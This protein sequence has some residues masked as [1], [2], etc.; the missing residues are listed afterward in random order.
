MLIKKPALLTEQDVTDYRLYQQRRQFLK[1]LGGLS[2]WGTG[3]GT[4]L[5]ASKDE[6]T[7]YKDITTYNNFIE[8]GVGKDAPA[9]LGHLIKTS[10]WEVT[11]DGECAK[12]GK[13]DLA[14][15]LKLYPPE[16]RIYS[17]RCV[18]GWSMV[19]PWQGFPLGKFLQRFAPTSK[20]KFVKF[21]SL[22]DPTQ[23]PA[24]KR[25]IALRQ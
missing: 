21:E 24:Q 13:L 10:S 12:P 20:A 2:L 23:M 18:E 15:I 1:T 22:Y 19:I 16:E 4:V 9:E 14:D 7:D 5:A 8:L 25:R 3:L 17:L 11:V 6:L